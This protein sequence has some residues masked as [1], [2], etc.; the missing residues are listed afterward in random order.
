[1][2]TRRKRPKTIKVKTIKQWIRNVDKGAV[3]RYPL[4]E[5]TG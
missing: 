5:V 1:M 2:T 4:R 3:I